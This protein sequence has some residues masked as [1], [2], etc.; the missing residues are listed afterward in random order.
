MKQFI[1]RLILFTALLILLLFPLVFFKIGGKDLKYIDN[2]ISSL[3]D[4]HQ[5]IE[6]LESPRLLITGGSSGFYGMNSERITDSLHINVANMALFA[7]LGLDFM[8]NELRDNIKKNDVVLLNIEYFLF[9]ECHAVEDVMLYYPKGKKY[10]KDYKEPF[11]EPYLNTFKVNIESI[12][13]FALTPIKRQSVIYVHSRTLNEYGDA[14]GYLKYKKP[15]YPASEKIAYRYYEGIEKLNQFKAQAEAM[16]AKVYFVFPPFPV[17]E[18]KLNQSIIDH[19]Y[20][21]FKAHLK[22]TML[23]NPIDMVYDDNLFYDS[24]YHL[25]KEG[26][27]LRTTRLI[28]MLKKVL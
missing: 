10:L 11:Y 9:P 16:G 8:L 22:I 28:G 6:T 23:C 24:H 18:Y 27:E 25:D 5:R 26:R 19:Y 21:D 3:I 13:N 1:L 20:A 14:V 2:P 12:Q 4:K 15:A 7:G 17:T